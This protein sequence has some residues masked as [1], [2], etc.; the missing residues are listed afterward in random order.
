[1]ANVELL[2]LFRTGPMTSQ[3]AVSAGVLGMVSKYGVLVTGVLVMCKVQLQVVWY[4]AV[5]PSRE[6]DV[7]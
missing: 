4:G 2:A 1:V 3:Q 7:Q 5:A 6:Q